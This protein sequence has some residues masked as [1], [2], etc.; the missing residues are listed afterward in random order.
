MPLE[1]FPGLP[2][3]SLHRITSYN[4]CYTKLLR[5]VSGSSLH[6]AHAI[7]GYTGES[8]LT[9]AAAYAAFGNGGTY[10]E[11]YSYTKLIYRDS[12]EEYVNEKISTKAMSEATAYIVQDMLVTTAQ[13]A[14]SKYIK[15]NGWSYSA[16]T[17]TTNF[18]SETIV[19]NGLASNAINDL[20]VTGF[21]DE[22]AIVIT[23]YSIHYT[24][25]YD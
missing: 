15:V 11:P 22:Y 13:H 6:E 2:R 4:V 12:D 20:W 8:P 1:L 9:L 16:K 21:T 10:N 19:A 7:G 25:L 24:K 14:L 5:E 18:S 3:Q 23:S 17:G